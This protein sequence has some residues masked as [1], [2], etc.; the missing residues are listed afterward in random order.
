[1]TIAT[2][3]HAGLLG[4]SWTYILRTVSSIEKVV[5]QIRKFMPIHDN[6]ESPVQIDLAPNYK[7]NDKP[8]TFSKLL[9]HLGFGMILNFNIFIILIIIFSFNS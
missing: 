5:S 8:T 2:D 3:E 9:S 6:D 1:M 7:K 4:S